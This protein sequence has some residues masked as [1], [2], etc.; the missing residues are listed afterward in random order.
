[1]SEFEKE[2]HYRLAKHDTLSRPFYYEDGLID[3]FKDWHPP[4]P[5][6]IVPQF[7]ADFIKALKIKGIKPLMDSVKFGE[8]GFTEEKLQEI[9]YWVNEHQEEY[10]RAWLDGYTVEKEQLYVLEFPLEEPKKLTETEIKAIDKRLM[11]F[12]VKV[13]EVDV[14]TLEVVE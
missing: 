3:T 9:V 11:A 1:M 4:K 2:L 13:D 7:V 14:D 8:I 12:A 6:V 5:F 10:M